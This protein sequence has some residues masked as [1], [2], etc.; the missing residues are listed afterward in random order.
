MEQQLEI[1]TL[2]RRPRIVFGASLVRRLARRAEVLTGLSAGELLQPNRSRTHSFTRFAVMMVAG[3]NGLGPCKIGHN[4]GVD[5]T[6]VI[7][8]AKRAAQI[9]EQDEDFAELVRLLRVEASRG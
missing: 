1:L 2:P 8:G 6:S 9:I 7:H 4:L 3:E 5:H